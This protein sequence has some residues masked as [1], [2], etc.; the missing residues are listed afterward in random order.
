M[1]RV[2][3]HLAHV[4]A[5]TEAELFQRDLQGHR[6][7]TSETCPDHLQS[8]VPA[9]HGSLPAACENRLP[10]AAIPPRRGFYT[11][12]LAEDTAFRGSEILPLLEEAGRVNEWY[13]ARRHDGKGRS[14]SLQLFVWPPGSEKDPRPRL[15]GRSV[16]R[17]RVHIGRAIRAP[18]RRPATEPGSPEHDLAASME[19]GEQN[20]DRSALRGRYSSDTKPRSPYGRL[21]SSLRTSYGVPGR[22]GLR[23][24]SRICV[25]PGGG[26]RLRRMR[27]TDMVNV[28]NR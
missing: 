7:R 26:A 20:I 27:Q 6:A 11:T 5:R 19:Q 17:G 24:F 25:R 23:S 15:L 28:A 16:L 14:Y 3:E 8:H 12:R 22:S 10:T 18:G 21:R 1:P 9:P 2:L 13:V 4:V